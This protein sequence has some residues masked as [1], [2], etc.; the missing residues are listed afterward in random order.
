MTEQKNLWQGGAWEQENFVAPPMPVVRIPAPVVQQAPEKP[1]KNARHKRKVAWLLIFALVLGISVA[2][3]VELKKKFEE[4][5]PPIYDFFS[6]P[7]NLYEPD[8]SIP[9]TIV[10]D[11]RGLGATI[12]LENRRGEEKTRGDIYK[13]NLQSMV[14]IEAW[15]DVSI[16]S[17]S[18]IVL[19]Q[20]GYIVTNGHVVSGMHSAEVTLW[21]EEVYTAKLVGWSYEEDLAVLK[22][23]AKNLRPA[24][25]GNS[26]QM[27]V[28]DS[29][30]AFGNPLGWE[31]RGTF[32]EGIISAVDRYLA[33]DEGY[34]NLIQTTAAINSGNSGG[35]L[36]NDEGQVIGITTIKIMA[37]DNTIESMGFA[38]PSTRVKQ[39][40]DK[41]I[42]GEEIKTPALG[43]VVMETRQP[44]T[45]LTVVEISK[46]GRA[47]EAGLQV[48]DIIISA[49]GVALRYNEDLARVKDKFLV[50]D[51]ITLVVYR[52]D[53]EIT[54]HLPLVDRDEIQVD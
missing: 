50:G 16:S 47:G 18:G 46:G 17:G 20:N 34:M 12:T 24:E 36:L 31:Y 11:R 15:D 13:E 37:D 53:E 33:V 6:Q 5:A 32:T 51:T 19:S 7:W 38:I 49:Q 41:L 44:V 27:Q 54:I 10:R 23:E 2:A 21:D 9:P 4:I 8:Y 1:K 40:V 52:E 42:A 29:A 45:G 3:A 39:I 48:D 30:Y 22:I 25:F 14:Y 35:A 28:G 43:I 26:D